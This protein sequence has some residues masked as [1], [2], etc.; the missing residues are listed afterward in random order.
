M[1]D[2][3]E[4]TKP[5]R[6]KQLMEMAGP[7]LAS[8]NGSLVE[9]GQALQAG[10]ELFEEMSALC[11]DAL[12]E[13]AN[14]KAQADGMPTPIPPMDETPTIPDPPEVPVEEPPPSPFDALEGEPKVPATPVEALHY[15]T[16]ESYLQPFIGERS[17]VVSTG[18]SADQIKATVLA[19]KCNLPGSLILVKLDPARP[20]M[21]HLKLGHVNGI[22]GPN[23]EPLSDV[24]IMGEMAASGDEFLLPAIQGIQ[25]AARNDAHTGCGNNVRLEFLEARPDG[26]GRCIII[27]KGAERSGAHLVGY[28]LTVRAIPDGDKFQGCGGKWGLLHNGARL[29]LKGFHAASA[30]EEHALYLHG[31]QG[32]VYV[33]GAWNTPSVIVHPGTGRKIRVG[34]G[35]T[36]FQCISRGNEVPMPWGDITLRSIRAEQ[37]GWQS[38]PEWIDENGVL[39][40][41]YKGGQ[42]GGSALTFAGVVRGRVKVHDYLGRDNYCSE[43]AVWPERAKGV[44]GLKV[45]PSETNPEGIRAYL[46]GLD[47]VPF[48]PTENTRPAQGYSVTDLDVEGFKVQR[49]RATREALILDGLGRARFLGASVNGDH[50]ALLEHERKVNQYPWAT[51]CGPIEFA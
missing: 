1:P 29:T 43:L 32:G 17:V 2:K 46:T 28:R 34:M 9:L 47:G 26:A 44:G 41:N 3:K 6:F 38:L 37:C 15:G 30:F 19:A 48:N 50:L 22:N 27:D 33:D 5:E 12:T 13:N 16:P 4:P 25:L 49:A 42:G 36:F 31:P 45:E 24:A 18:M 20:V 40:P 10:R 21:G 7:I 39:D 51:P 8:A 11:M 14:L 23:G 35:R